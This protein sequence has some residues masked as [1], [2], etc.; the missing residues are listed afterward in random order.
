MMKRMAVTIRK[1][2]LSRGPNVSEN[3]GRGCF[4]SQSFKID[5]IPSWDGGREDARL[6]S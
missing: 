4:G 6:G 3:E 1:G 2:A 5:T